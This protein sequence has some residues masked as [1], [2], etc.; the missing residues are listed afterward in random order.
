MWCVTGGVDSAV[1]LGYHDKG[2]PSFEY[3]LA[4][5]IKVSND[6][7]MSD[8]PQVLDLGK[9]GDAQWQNLARAAPAEPLAFF[10]GHEYGEKKYT[11]G[12]DRDKIVAPKCSRPAPPPTAASCALRERRAPLFPLCCVCRFRETTFELLGGVTELNFNKL[13]WGDDEA[14]Q[15]AVVLPLCAKLT[16]LKLVGNQVGDRGAAAL[17]GAIKGNGALKDLD[18]NSNQIGAAGA[19]ALADAL[20]VNGA[21]KALSLAGN[22]IGEDSKSKL[23]TKVMRF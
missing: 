16:E 17:A 18:L 12:A 8:W 23:R 3:R 7:G 5:M 13:K 1:G 20:R 15:L 6:S 2:W 14:V 22:Q 4:M 21:M 10:G 9:Q 19:A 11:N